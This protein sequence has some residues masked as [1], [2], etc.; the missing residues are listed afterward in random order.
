MFENLNDILNVNLNNIIDGTVTIFFKI[1]KMPIEYWNRVPLWFKIIIF[2]II[3]A[4][5]ILM[6][7]ITIRY[8]NAWRYRY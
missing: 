5:A 4:F 6:A 2:A 8:R 7:F 3:I 1:V